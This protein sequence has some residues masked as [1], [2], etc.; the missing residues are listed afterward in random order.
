MLGAWL[1][2]IYRA[3]PLPLEKKRRIKALVF[4]AL[5]PILGRGEG[6]LFSSGRYTDWVK[7][8]DTLTESERSAIRADIARM[9]FTPRISVVM[10]VYNTPEVF[11]RRAID[12]VINQLY[13]HWELCIADDASPEPHI[14]RV[15]EEY[16]A[17]ES[18]IRVIYREENGHI[19]AASNSA[20]VLATGEF[21]ALLDHDDELPSHA[22]YLVA[23]EI[24][25]H[26]DADIVYSD[27]DKIDEAGNRYDPHF[28]SD[29]NPE[30]L[31]S[32]NYIS[33]LGVYRRSLVETVGGF[34]A[35]YEGSQDYDLLLRCYA[36]TQPACV[37]HIPRVLY[38]W[39]A[40]SGSTARAVDEKSY[41]AEAARSAL[42]DYFHSLGED[43]E[44]THG[45]VPTTYRV[46]FPLPRP[47]PLV[48]IIIPTRNG[49][50]LLCT[51][52]SSVLE[53]T[54]YEAYEIIIVDN[55][56][57]EPATLAYLGELRAHPRC[58]VLRYDAPFNFSAI[59]NCAVR[60]ARGEFVL[61]LNNDTE[62]ISPEWL[63]EL[64]M[65]GSREGIGAVGC[66]LFY[67]D[68]T[69][70]H[71]GVILGIG[72]VAGHCH[73]YCPGDLPGYFGRMA[74]VHEAGGNTAACLLVRRNTY[75]SVGGLDEE[76]LRV[77]F[78]DVDFCLKLRQAGL[79]N[80]WTPY[81]V[82]YHHESKTRGY[83]DTPDKQARF[84]A[85]IEFMQGRWGDALLHDPA[86]SP[87]LTLEREDFS[88]SLAWPPRVPPL[89]VQ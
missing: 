15:L 50:Q 84:Q 5:R 37:H 76:N 62:V 43:A 47:Q 80:L 34:R 57:D 48:S 35:G 19:S 53:K 56:S 18:R 82:L 75:L 78:N 8:Y 52:V 4:S 74:T 79:R 22:L 42:E 63:E 3:V 1:R 55:Q 68:G 54:H 85:E 12:S 77:A 83:E 9:G 13:P 88:F 61:L 73:K 59:N 45:P 24:E 70:Q 36:R 72:G 11:L 25:A 2:R 6:R 89:P 51:C 28:K 31:Y 64:V 20:L 69:I 21:V 81:A 71:A 38:H 67:P 46:R 16:T 23:K 30:L 49:V 60:E 39:R 65:W 87:N 33:H 44:V 27:E 86:Y 29:V 32:Q 40:V 26:P 41:A 58:R 7:Q 14:H 17:R 10:P 66:K